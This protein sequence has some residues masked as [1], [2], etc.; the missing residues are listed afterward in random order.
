M[1]F[2]KISRDKRFLFYIRAF[3]V[4]GVVMV[5]AIVINQLCFLKF[6]DE[7]MF[8]YQLCTLFIKTFFSIICLVFLFIFPQK[9]EIFAIVCFVYSLEISISQLSNFMNVVLFFLGINLLLIR[10]FFHRK[11]N[12]IRLFFT[13][14]LFFICNLSKIRFG[15]S[16]FFHSF[17]V[18]WGYFFVCSMQV[19][20]FS[21]F[22]NLINNGESKSLN[23]AKFK[24]LHESDVFLLEAVL[25]NMQYKVIASELNK[26]EGT[27][28]NRLNKIYD[29]LGVYDKMGFIS[30]YHGCDIT[31]SV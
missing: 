8:D 21:Y 31:Y 9:I 1:S 7:L 29:V 15:F 18:F 4:I 23:L 22:K 30:K 25:N 3:T 16:Q 11:Q 20:L 17:F 26:K 12:K 5:F 13:F 19:V 27:V 10:G 14:I 2:E 6:N 24:D 28:R